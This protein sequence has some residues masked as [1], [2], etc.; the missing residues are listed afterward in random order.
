MV[1]FGPHSFVTIYGEF[2]GP[3]WPTSR[4]AKRTAE[5]RDES[6]VKLTRPRARKAWASP[7]CT[8]MTTSGESTS[9]SRRFWALRLAWLT[10]AAPE[11]KEKTFRARGM[12]ELSEFDAEREP[13][14]LDMY[15]DPDDLTEYFADLATVID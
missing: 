13:I 12:T 6:G 14:A 5:R 2:G 15:F 8:D 3:V 1:H 9:W 4:S 11:G 7:T 10:R